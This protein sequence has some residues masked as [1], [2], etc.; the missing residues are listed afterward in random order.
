MKPWETTPARWRDRLRPALA[1]NRAPPPFSIGF[2]V[3]GLSFAPPFARHHGARPASPR[4]EASAHEQ[5]RTTLPLQGHAP[6]RHA[7]EHPPTVVGRGFS[8][9]DTAEAVPYAKGSAPTVVGRGF[10]RAGT[11]EAVPYAAP[12][13]RGLR[14]GHTRRRA[15]GRPSRCTRRPLMRS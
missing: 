8:R 2:S 9:A 10:S 5:L 12:A 4:P 7:C 6:A 1:H 14:P 3:S 11:A 15:D 13:A